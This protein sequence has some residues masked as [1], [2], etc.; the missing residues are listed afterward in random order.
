MIELKAF[1]KVSWLSYLV[2]AALAL[3][4]GVTALLVEQT[5]SPVR[6]EI[7]IHPYRL[8]FGKTGPSRTV[9]MS[10]TQDQLHDVSWKL[11]TGGVMLAVITM[12]AEKM[13]EAKN[14]KGGKS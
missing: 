12:I 14:D 13:L 8:T 9:Y 7:F 3:G 11:S 4:G 2:G 6:T 10:N 1:K 5:A